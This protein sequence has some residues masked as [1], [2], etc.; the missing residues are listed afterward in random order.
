MS[1]PYRLTPNEIDHIVKLAYRAGDI[2]LRFF[3]KINPQTKPDKTFVTSVDLDV[4]RFLAGQIKAAYPGHNL[5][6]EEGVQNTFAPDSA[7]TWVIDPL[8]GTTAFIQGLPGWGISIGLLHYGQPYFGLFYMPL[9]KDLTYTTERAVYCNGFLLRHT[10]KNSWGEKG[11]LAVNATAHADFIINAPRTRALGSTG[12]NLV[13]TARGSATGTFIPKAYVWDLAAGAAILHNAGGEI[14]YL[15]GH[16]INYRDLLDERLAPAPIV[17]AH[18]GLQA[19]L[20]QTIG[21]RNKI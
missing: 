13:Y 17:A 16:P 10:V 1:S 19:D 18:P 3:N 15:N 21:F 8:D 2:T 6:G 11:F 9:L 12:A 4:E 20:R 5:V 7:N 14:R